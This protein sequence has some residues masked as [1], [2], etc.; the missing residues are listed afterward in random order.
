LAA[1]SLLSLGLAVSLLNFQPQNKVQS[2]RAILLYFYA[3]YLTPVS[4]GFSLATILFFTVL[5]LSSR[6]SSLVKWNGFLAS[7]AA[8]MATAITWL[9]VNGKL[10]L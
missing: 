4:F 7:A 9:V 3:L 2:A 10:H 8:S 5:A 6:V 1:P